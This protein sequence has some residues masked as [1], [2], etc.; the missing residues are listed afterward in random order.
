M[1][2]HKD[3][4]SF[5]DSHINSSSHHGRGVNFSLREMIGLVTIIALAVALWNAMSRMREQERELTVMRQEFGYLAPSEPN[6]LAA[7][8]SPSEQPLSYR[9]RIRLPAQKGEDFPYQVVYSS[10]WEAGNPDPTWFGGVRVPSGESLVTVQIIDDPRDG[11]W[12]LATVVSS[13]SGTS[14]MST[15]LPAPHEEIFRGSHDVISAAIGRE[16]LISEV[17]SSVR[18]L[19]ERWLIDGAGVVLDGSAPKESQVGVYAELQ[20]L[21]TDEVESLGDLLSVE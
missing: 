15:V 17:G 20:P 2:Q 10:L 13:Q 5:D 21:V 7:S 1:A 18:L 3:S 11:R 19:D 16:T 4:E 12:K 8:R 6:E 14:R 9:M